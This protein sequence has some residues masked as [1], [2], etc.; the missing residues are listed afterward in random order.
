MWTG[1]SG[2]GEHKLIWTCKGSIWYHNDQMRLKT[3]LI[4]LLLMILRKGE[5]RSIRI[6]F[7]IQHVYMSRGCSMKQDQQLRSVWFH[8]TQ[9][10]LAEF[11]TQVHFKHPYVKYVNSY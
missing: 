3:I 6:C 8:F 11:Y 2:W 5:L 9:I 4:I 10:H 1:A 7:Y